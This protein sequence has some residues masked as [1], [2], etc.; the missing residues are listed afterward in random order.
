[1]PKPIYVLGTSLSHD[2]SVCLLKDGHVAVA[3][4]KER[5]TRKKHDGYND[6]AA[7]E[8]CLKAANIRIQDLTLI[9]QNSWAGMFERGNAWFQGQRILDPA[10]PVVTISHHL[11][12]AYS[13]YATS[14]YHEAHVL[15]IDNG[16]N[17]LGECIDLDGATIPVSPEPELRDLYSEVDSY[18]FFDATGGRTI[19]KDFSP[20]GFTRKPYPMYPQPMMHSIGGLYRAVSMYVFNNL[21]DPG[22]LMGLAP[23]GRPGVYDFSIFD[24]RGGRV[25]VLYDWQHRFNR[26]AR[27]LDELKA[28]FQY[29]ADIAYWTQKE[30]ERAILYVAESRLAIETAKNF[31]YAGGVALNA[32]AN[33]KL[34]AHFD[35]IYIQPAAADNGISLGCAFFGWLRVLQRE[36]VMHD[37][38]TFFG[39]SYAQDDVVR[40]ID[41][42]DAT[43]LIHR[44]A[45]HIAETAR[46]LAEGKIVGWYQ[47]GSEFGPRALGNR[48]I[49]AD[50]R[51]TH[52]QD[53]INRHVKNREDF[54]PFAP[55]VLLEDR[56]IYFHCPVT[57]PYM[58]LVAPVKPEWSDVIRS[59]VHRDQT[60]RLQT[61]AKEF[62]PVYYRLLCEF[63]SRTGLGVLLNTSLN[64][65]GMPIVETPDQAVDLFLTSALDVLVMEDYVLCKPGM[66]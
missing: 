34:L 46:F 8:Y 35:N 55:S 49:L 48:S 11:A 3:I 4:E 52:V 13:A 9:V 32:V 2:G 29:Y 28:H 54:R 16:G 43:K 6:T 65:R 39:V 19:F 64:R 56:D 1:M 57:S 18:Y 63:K 33:R 5:L 23:Y 37:G 47:K 44:S 53:F 21:D 30:I 40:A 61:V 10:I 20:P 15:V 50:P 41:K 62:N 22:K 66:G 38:S 27:S 59:V 17:S 42:A 25:R 36:R 12:H 60:S 45:D 51:R 26:P 14:P 7:I 58:L 31:C 24:L